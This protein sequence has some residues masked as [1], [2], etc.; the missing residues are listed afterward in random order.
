[1]VNNLDKDTTY[2]A[3]VFIQQ[4]NISVEHFK[5]QQFVIP[6]FHTST[7]IQTGVPGIEDNGQMLQQQQ[8]FGST[9]G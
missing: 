5:G 8:H 9:L 6:V 3:K 1:M 7:E 4:F 2:V